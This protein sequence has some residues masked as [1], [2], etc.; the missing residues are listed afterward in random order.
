MRHLRFAEVHLHNVLVLLQHGQNRQARGER[1]GVAREV[2][3][4]E[5]WVL[6]QRPAEEHNRVIVEPTAWDVE[7]PQ[8]L[9]LR[10]ETRHGLKAHGAK[11]VAGEVHDGAVA[12]SVGPQRQRGVYLGLECGVVGDDFIVRLAVLH[13]ERQCLR[14]LRAEL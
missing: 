8:V 12:N 10:E 4:R 11:V 13:A 1:D 14:R 9:V 2:Y 3:A 6:H 5:A 7:L